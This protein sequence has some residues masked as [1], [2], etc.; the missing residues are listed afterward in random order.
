[1]RAVPPLKHCS[2]RQKIL[3]LFSVLSILVI[4]SGLAQQKEHQRKLSPVLN[5][6]LLKTGMQEKIKFRI[7]LKGTAFPGELNKPKYEARKIRADVNFTI[8]T[9]TCTKEDFYN[10]VLPSAAVLFVEDASRVPKEEM[11]VGNLDLAT[12]KINIAHSRFPQYNGD[13][14][15]VSVKENKPDTTDIDLEGRWLT[16][17]LSSG[18]VSSHASIMSTM[19]GGG[20]NSWYLGKGAAWGS[21]LSS[22]DFASLLPDAN[23]AYQQYNISVQNHSYGVGVES[24]YGSDAAAYDGSA[25]DNSYLLHIFSAGNSGTDA[26]TTGTYAGLPGFA[27]L[28]GSFKMAKNIITAGSTDSFSSV[29]VLSSKGP[30][31]D[32]RVKPELVAFGEDGSSGAAALVSGTA[33]LL[34]DAYKQRYGSLP[35]NALVKAILLNSADDVGNAEVD[36]ASGFGALN[37][38]N[39]MQTIQA[40]RFLGG[41]VTNGAAQTFTV[42]IPAGIK[43]LKG[44]IVWNDPPASPN[45]AK[46]LVNDL[47]LELL[48]PSSG[49]SWR[50][51]VLNPFPHPDSLQQPA[52]RK[53]DS[54]NNVEQVTLDNPVA[55]DYQFKVTGSKVTTPSQ[56]FYIA[57]QFDSADVF[58][59]QFPTT[60]DFIFSS[61][62]NVVRWKSSFSGAA[63]NLEFSI[64]DG[65]NWQTIQNTLDLTA[66]H[67]KWDGP[68]L[69]GTAQLRMTIGSKQFISDT[70][71]L[72]QRISTGVGFNCPDSF[73]IYWNKIQ[74]VNDYRIFKLGNKYLEPFLVTA[75]SLLILDKHANPSLYYAV[76]PL[77]NNREGVKS[78]TFNYTTQGVECYI[79]SFLALLVDNTV[80]L[81][82]TLGTLYNVNRITLEKNDGA[83]YIQLQQ[84]TSPAD[85][86]MSFSD[87]RLK[88]G[89]NIYRIKLALNN[90]TVIY[91]QPETVYYFSGSVFI[92]YPNPARQDQPI[93]ILSADTLQNTKLQVLN[94]LGQKVYE[95]AIDDENLQIPAGRLSKGLYLFRFVRNGEKDI[96]LK[97]LIL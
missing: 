27:N 46:S 81:D 16:T 86:K 95:L 35:P 13:G 20:G 65:K 59:W 14:I 36:Y 2:G 11:L 74:D 90:G 69:T 19:I 1:M 89:L 10:T 9:I 92:V 91:S 39:G 12:N 85:L 40:T 83:N 31:Y 61:A 15:T 77:I 4:P 53:R 57:Y 80:Q 26:A 3:L 68:S 67:Y 49:Q 52:A 8:V 64:D 51:W 87:T 50:P 48:Y 72:S 32:G 79:R 45:A 24:Y 38:Y 84:L 43:K 22:S 58:E 25:I 78:Y 18:V 21:T 60:N 6:R 62:P 88:K 96:V 41:T 28:T 56:A 37:A 55:G 7:T 75:D 33:L 47:D 82:L 30:A 44:T 42:S 71:T 73:L 17:G 97:V 23:T 70:F 76:A 5:T 94:T 34:Q 93:H 66:G 63:G 29:P 54:L